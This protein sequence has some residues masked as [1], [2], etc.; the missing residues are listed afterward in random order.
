MSYPEKE[1]I[2]YNN[3]CTP[4][5]TEDYEDN[6]T[7]CKCPVCSGFLPADIFKDPLICK[8]CGSELVAI[9]HSE[10]FK[11]SDDYDF[12]EGKICVVNRRQKTK[13]QTKEEREIKRLCKEGAKREYAFL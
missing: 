3:S 4:Y 13:Q 5:V 1:E 9:E 11:E 7:P 6:H 10:E 8:K 12:S 2:T